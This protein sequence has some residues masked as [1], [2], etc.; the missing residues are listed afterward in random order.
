MLALEPSAGRPGWSGPN[1]PFA[2]RHNEAVPCSV[3]DAFAECH[4]HGVPRVARRAREGHA[5]LARR[6]PKRAA[7]AVPLTEE[8]RVDRDA[9]L[10]AFAGVERDLG[11]GAQPFRTFPA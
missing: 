5:V 8:A 3:H 11:E 10:A 4:R 6:D 7:R 2:L 1:G 9:K